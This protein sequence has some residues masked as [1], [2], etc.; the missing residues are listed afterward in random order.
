VS[1]QFGLN[2]LGRGHL[3]RDTALVDPSLGLRPLGGAAFMGLWMLLAWLVPVVLTA[4]PDIPGVVLGGAVLAAALATFFFA[5]WGLHRQ[6][7]AVKEE[8]LAFARKLYAQ[9]YDP[10][11]ANPSLASLEE[12]RGLL[13]AAM[14]P[15]GG[16]ARAR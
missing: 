11:R 6:M 4:L 9:A 8:E 7:V 1:L 10:L 5:M 14:N 12:Q 15:R 13:G 3:A 16:T 2:R